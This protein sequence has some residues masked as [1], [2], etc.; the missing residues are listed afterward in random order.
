MMCSPPIPYFVRSQ[1]KVSLLIFL[2]KYLRGMF[3]TWFHSITSSDKLQFHITHQPSFKTS[4]IVFIFLSCTLTSVLRFCFVP[5]DKLFLQIQKS[6]LGFQALI[7]KWCWDVV[8]SWEWFLVGLCSFSYCVCLYLDYGM[9]TGLK[10][11]HILWLAINSY[12]N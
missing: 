11:V 4:W 5:L 2:V 9:N 3:A 1:G 10:Q 12:R 6:I 7:Y 8:L